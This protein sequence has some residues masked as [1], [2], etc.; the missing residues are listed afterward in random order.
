[1]KTLT[2]ITDPVDGL[3]RWYWTWADA[4][5]VRY[6]RACHGPFVSEAAANADAA[7]Y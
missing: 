5:K 4:H 3:P 2:K 1:M 7:R 6:E